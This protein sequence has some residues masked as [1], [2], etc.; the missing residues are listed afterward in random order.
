MLQLET[1]EGSF[2]LFVPEPN[3]MNSI[4]QVSL[5]LEFFFYL[6]LLLG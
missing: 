3:S 4:T 1:A 2:S 6:K 5:T